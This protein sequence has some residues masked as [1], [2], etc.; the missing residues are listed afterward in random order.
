[1][2]VCKPCYGSNTITFASGCVDCITSNPEHYTVV[3]SIDGVG[4]LV[5]MI[6]P[7]GESDK[8]H[9]HPKHSMYIVDGAKLELSPPPGGKD[10]ETAVVELPSGAAPIIPAGKHVV[11]N[12]GDTT[13]KV[14][15]DFYTK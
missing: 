5:E 7:P 6:V 3:A 14:G 12:V 1:M 4:R 2:Q 15:S 11:K 8:V 10:G 9:D 13:A